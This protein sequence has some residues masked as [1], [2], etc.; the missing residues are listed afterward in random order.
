MRRK[1]L[2][3]EGTHLPL[4]PPRPPAP[5]AP[6]APPASLALSPHRALGA[7]ELPLRRSPTPAPRWAEL[8]SSRSTGSRSGWHST[9]A[10][11]QPNRPDSWR[12]RRQLSGWEGRTPTPSRPGQPRSSSACQ[13]STGARPSGWTW[14]KPPVRGGWRW[15][16]RE[17]QGPARHRPPLGPGL[18]HLARLPCIPCDSKH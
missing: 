12:E 16:L 15:H 4:Q 7:W 17:E 6:P 10:S 1:H 14:S 5:R 13:S 3:D 18:G 11:A 2:Q 8:P 9:P